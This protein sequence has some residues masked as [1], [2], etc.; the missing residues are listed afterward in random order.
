[1]D[2]R[3]PVTDDVGRRHVEPSPTAAKAAYSKLARKQLIGSRA[4]LDAV[5]TTVRQAI[6]TGRL[7][8]S[9]QL[10]RA[11]EVMEINLAAAE[12]R[13]RRL[14]KSGEEDWDRRRIDLES[15][16][17]DLAR[18]IKHVVARFADG[19]RQGFE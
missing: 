14:Q 6:S 15:A 7:Q 17:E 3:E 9:E 5:R 11:L 19:T 2:T 12:T 4:K 16:Q 10:E 1:M 13:L 8:P 18:S